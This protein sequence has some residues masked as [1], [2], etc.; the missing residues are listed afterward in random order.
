MRHETIRVTW[1]DLLGKKHTEKLTG[2]N[3]IVIQ[4]EIDHL[5]GILYIDKLVNK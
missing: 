2:Y 5:D 4:R 1:T 3:A